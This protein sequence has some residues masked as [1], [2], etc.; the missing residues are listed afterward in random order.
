MLK[1]I[2]L[3]LG[4]VRERANV[5]P[6]GVGIAQA[7]QARICR[8]SLLDTRREDNLRLTCESAIHLYFEQEKRRQM[9]RDLK[10]HRK[11][12]TTACLA[13]DLDFDVRRLIG[14]PVQELPGLAKFHNLFI[15]AFSDRKSPGGLTGGQIIDLAR[16]DARSILMLRESARP[17]QRVLRAAD[18]FDASR[19]AIRVYLASRPFPDASHRVLGIAE[20]E[21]LA[22]QWTHEVL[23]ECRAKLG[24]V[25]TGSLVGKPRRVLIPYLGKWEADMVVLGLPKALPVVDRLLGATALRVLTKTECVLF[26][27]A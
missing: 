14:N 7:S 20:Q 4:G 16:R 26:A 25:E 15:T 6:C 10:A 22:R 17:I 9:E 21:M 23:G 2:L 8:D 13:A 18:G 11:D 19:N 27:S 24:N 1:S 12:L 5:I 3:H